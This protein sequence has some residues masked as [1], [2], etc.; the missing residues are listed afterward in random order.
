MTEV[1][2][3]TGALSADTRAAMSQRLRRRAPRQTI[4]PRPAG[5]PVPLSSGQERL[6]FMEQFAP[7]TTAYAISLAHRL[8]GPLDVAKLGQALTALVARHESLR[9]RFP[10]T[11][12]GRPTV[13]VDPPAPVR[14]CVV[15]VAGTVG[16][17]RDRRAASLVD[18]AAALPYDLAAGPLLRL[19]LVRFGATD[20]VL[21]IGM[22][23]II[24]DGI[25]V[26]ILMRE[27]LAC[28]EA[29][30]TG[31]PA[32]L[33]ELPVQFGDYALWERDRLTG[34]ASQADL[35]YWREQLR[36]L[37]DLALPTDRPRPSEPCFD[38]ATHDF[39]W[40]R[41]LTG[42]V[43]GLGRRHRAT[44][45]MTL[46]AAFQATL[47]RF[48]GQDDFAVGSPV[49]GRPHR[50]LDGV[51][52]A[53]VNMLAVRARCEGDPTFGEVLARVRD[54]T[55]DALAHQELPFDRIVTDL[56]ITRDA[57]RSPVF[58]VTFAL[59]T[60]TDVS[61]SVPS[62]PATVTGL[63][64]QPFDVAHGY[65]QFDLAVYVVEEADGLSFHVSYRTD[66]FEA[67]TVERIGRG[68]ELL[69]RAAAGDPG[70]RLSDLPVLTTAERELVLGEWSGTVVRDRSDGTLG[71][72]VA[73]SAARSPDAPAVVHDGQVLTHADLDRRSNQLAHRLRRLGIGPEDR[74][75]IRLEPSFDL[76][77]S[78]LA[79]LKAGGAYLPIDPEQPPERLAYLLADSGSR[80]LLTDA[81]SVDVP[82]FGGTVLDLV[83][84]RGAV[85][86]ERDA[87]LRCP[88]GPANLAYVIYTS[89]TTGRPKG[90]AVAHRD[91]VDY[92][93]S[94]RETL[95]IEPGASF[96]LVQSTAFDFSMLMFYLPLITGGCLHLLPRRASGLELATAVGRCDL[97]YLKM[98][99]SHLTAL[100]AD[101]E[102]AQL[103]PRR[104]LV[105]AGEASPAGWARDL[106]TA[107]RCAVVNSY[108]PTETVVAVTTAR[109][110]PD[111]DGAGTLPIGRPMPNVRLYVLDNRMRPV[112]PG[113]AG[114]L[115]VGGQ[116]LARGYLGR[117]A[118]TAGRFVAD[119][120]G[121]P[122]GRL[123][124]TGDRVRWGADGNLRFLGRTDDQV[125]VRGYR[126]EPAEVEAVLVDLPGVAQAAVDLRGPAGLER[127]VAYLERAAG[128]ADIAAADLRGRL[129]GRLPEYMV[130][131]HFVW[132]DRLPL[133]AHGKIDRDALPDPPD[134]SAHDD[135]G[136][137][138]PEGATERV[139]ARIWA[140]LLG[141]ERVGRR[142]NFF[143]LGG[144]S[145][146]ATQM[147]ARMRRELP[148]AGQPVRVL[149][150]FRHPTVAE[151]AA[152]AGR[153]PERSAPRRL[154]HELTRA[155][156]GRQ[157]TATLV[158]VPW[159]GADAVVYQPL[160]DALPPGYSLLSVAVPGREIGVE[161]AQLP[162]PELADRCVE[163]IGER[164]RGP[165]ILY[166]HCGP[167][168]AL[169]VAVALRLEAAGHQLQGLYLGGIFPFARPRGRLLGALSG[170]AALDRVRSERVDALW[171]RGMGA[172]LA[173]LDAEQVRFMVKA[174][175]RDGRMAEDYFTGL[176]D[177]G[178][179]TLRAPVISVVGEKDAAT[180]FYRERY[181]EW[182]FLSESLGLV[183]L[184]EAGHFFPK[185]RAGELAGILTGT[186]PVVPAPPTRPA[187]GEPA[188]AA[189]APEVRRAAGPAPSMRR[190]LTV[191]SGQLISIVGSAL[192]AF[193]I[194]VWVYVNT[195]SLTR[196]GLVALLAFLPGIL[197]APLAGAVVDRRDRRQ[198]MMAGDLACGC[199]QAVLL[200]LVWSGGT[201]LWAVYGL[202]A[203]LSVTL[204]FQRLAYT[205]AVAQLVPKRYLGH[206]NGVVQLVLGIAQFL[207]PLVAVGLLAT[208][209]LRGILVFDVGGYAFAV[210]V[211]LFVRFPEAT[212]WQRRE[213]MAAEIANGFRYA[214]GQRGF[215]N[216]LVFFAALNLFLSPLEV[217][218]VPLVLSFSSMPAVAGVSVTAG[219]GAVCGGLA[220]A[221]WGGPRHRRM[222]GV[223]AAVLLM[224]ASGL[225][226]G[227]RP[228]LLSV[229]AGMFG[230]LFAFT[231][232]NGIILTIVQVKVA[233]RFQGR[234]IAINTM[235]AGVT[236]PLGLGL[237][238]PFGSRVLEPLVRSHG[239]LAGTVGAVIGVGPG[240]GIALLYVVCGL[241][242]AALSVAAGR[243]RVLA[244]FDDEVPDALPDDL[245]G[246][247]QLRTTTEDAADRREPAARHGRQ[248]AER[249]PEGISSS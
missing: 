8:R 225:V 50:E 143:D 75:A 78:V 228:N 60:V 138:A 34:A 67:A 110:G 5:T 61:G 248:A 183:V 54:T 210:L 31:R 131:T 227:L 6:W 235:V 154:L 180:E 73:L 201:R 18:E 234:I 137:A 111:G 101:V 13:V 219:A 203:L 24:S 91:I 80:V 15:D 174:M 3:R 85:G 236:V 214:L 140:E 238:A 93:E 239:P 12:D 196:L 102:A 141:I 86:R 189:R 229:G 176:L 167:G 40:D 246:L 115:Y 208:I 118:L 14:L 211:V 119:P 33:P 81:S 188:G 170:L 179:Q 16:A 46:M 232:V 186:V 47:A 103:L 206:A 241:V 90:V 146:V 45:Y 165:I 132:M 160:A 117:P 156:P 142:D 9:M 192:T 223:R 112:P 100:L 162:V 139:V 216:M 114:E 53:F 120:F 221:W 55:I 17:E 240:R 95:G 37:P 175:R 64:V 52:G 22:H 128:T 207:V 39:R 169:A 215:R 135:A 32:A 79:V 163:E 171:L 148:G 36:D 70:T 133:K 2:D 242:M 104:A 48:C 127:L 247:Q 109:V 134:G 51:V 231:L 123:Y 88:A 38:G 173:G 62:E 44:V 191:A 26:D 200:A 121:Q 107:G 152:L 68:M 194:P 77:V 220:L 190:F 72:L 58:Q 199:I 212:P 23:H 98:T 226:V 187:P 213:S 249:T 99:P 195:G 49:A 65:T 97:D 56:G 11:A 184:D 185:Y 87:A 204:T 74:V 193:A 113:V 92:L 158:C 144:H 106:A 218:L 66:L 94:V 130:P 168:S 153:Q 172:D 27:L 105:L 21:F 245:V 129:A 1:S 125:K 42:A 28:Y 217:L 71:E 159:G 161:E 29:S 25:S 59:N 233:Q 237:L 122:G 151:L 108:G 177:A 63:S 30:C 230:M 166:G 197:A 84:Q 116:R 124:R 10:A 7:G 150:V 126:V 209:G 89:G 82:G 202:V 244:R 224:A 222:D 178:V 182:G 20:H 136:F 205:S 157:P 19:M 147:V 35:A 96:G 43:A 41:A 145:L 69:V 83:S 76:V 243:N 4:E 155:V 164:V 198:V 181:R 57:G 149:D